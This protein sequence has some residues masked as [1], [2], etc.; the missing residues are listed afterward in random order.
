MKHMEKYSQELKKCVYMCMTVLPAINLGVDAAPTVRHLS[1]Q[2]GVLG[3]VH[4]ALVEGPGDLVIPM[5]C[6][7]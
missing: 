3:Q 2:L 7:S 6:F 5:R 4:V 1:H